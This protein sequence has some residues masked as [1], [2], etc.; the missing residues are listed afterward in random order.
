MAAIQMSIEKYQDEL[1]RDY[2]A[3]KIKGDNEGIYQSTI[4][5]PMNRM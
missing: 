5:Y 4:G 3:A 1:T 2:V